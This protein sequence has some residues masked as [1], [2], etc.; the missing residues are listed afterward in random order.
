MTAPQIEAFLDEAF[1]EAR[2]Y[3]ESRVEDVADGS[4]RVRRV[5]DERHLRP[6][7]TVAG[8]VL[9]ALADQAAFV[10]V[11]SALGPVA[12]AVTTHLGIDFLRRPKVADVVAE[13]EVLK[14]GRRLVVARVTL[15]SDGEDAPIAHAT[16]T[17]SIPPESA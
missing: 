14:L 1:P 3:G 8:P 16:V 4:V 2:A 7:G 9:M 10:L 17:Y 12:L 5:I 6:G 15:R 11:L 13:A